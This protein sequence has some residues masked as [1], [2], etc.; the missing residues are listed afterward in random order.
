MATNRKNVLN[1]MFWNAKS[2]KNKIA[3]TADFI[4]NKNID[5]ALFTETW[6]RQNQS[7]SIPN[8]KTYFNNRPDNNAGNRAV[9]GGVAIAINCNIAHSLLPNFN[10]SVIEAIGIEVHGERS[11][12]KIIAVYFPGGKINS[13]KLNLFRRD[14]RLLSGSNSP[15]LICGDLNAR[16]RFWNCVRGNSTGRALYDEMTNHNFLI[17]FP[18]GPT[19]YPSQSGNRTPSTI[20][21]AISSGLLGVGNL[22]TETS[23]NSDHLP[24]T[25]NL[26]LSTVFSNNLA[27]IRCY[28]R[29]NWQKY[30]HEIDHGID[31]VTL[32][33][34]LTNINSIDQTISGFTSII[35]NAQNSS[36][37]TRV[38][39][40]KSEPLPF[41]IKR[42]IN[43]RNC[44]RRQWQRSRSDVLRIE[45]NYLNRQIK[46]QISLMRANAFNKKLSEFKNNSRQLWNVTKFL[47]NGCN[48][49]PALKDDNQRYLTTDNEKANEIG[50]AFCNAHKIT[51]DAKSD[52]QTESHVASSIFNLG[53]LFP[54]P[55]TIKLIKPAEVIRIVST[56]KSRKSPGNDNINNTLIKHLPKR[57]FVLLTYIFNACLR[58]G[59][60]PN[61]WKLAKVI[62][63]PKP[64]K[65]LSSS[66]NYRPI[67]LLSG[68]SKIFERLLL[69]R[70]SSHNATKNLVANEQFGFRQGH[71]TNHQLLRLSRHIRDGFSAGKSTGVITFD[72]EKAF[73]SVWH[74]GLLHKMFVMKYPFYLIKII[75]S[76]LNSRSFYV[77]VGDTKSITFQVAAGVPQGSVLSP[78]LYN[79]FTSDLRVPII[80]CQVALFADDTAFYASAKNPGKIIRILNASAQYL[81]DY[82]SRWKVKL[83]STKTQAV[84]FTKRRAQQ[85]LPDVD[86][87][88]QNASVPW[89]NQIKYLGVTL[90]SKLT[91]GQHVDLTVQKIQKYIAILYPLIGKRSKLGKFNKLILYK[92]FF[93]SI[94]LFA[95]PVWAKCAQCHRDKLQTVQNRCL[96]IILGLPYYFPTD[97]L[98]RIA[99][100]EK[101]DRQIAKIV[102]RFSDKLL[103]SSNPLVRQLSTD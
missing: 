12:T 58:L 50:N 15:F 53:F 82:C 17:H 48:R 66:K 30:K 81:S 39:S 80:G 5:I 1:I 35:E 100:V 90:D 59:Y 22:S 11:S 52:I 7:V 2:L 14:L 45:I 63:I 99:G 60:F 64:G 21:V 27:Y 69:S 55:N 49:L 8:F 34:S 94:L 91:Y 65:D 72:I 9:G 38:F 95:C 84:Y 83:N 79:I 75:Q 96:K 6:L 13:S 98:H 62:P 28:D 102:T 97:A 86:L 92:N 67:S 3:E 25:F 73:D 47:K 57:A 23:L 37:P 33:S 31:L 36:V 18:P 89:L 77:S 93:Q 32:S 103:T 71:S 76:Y 74:N 16:H 101:V 42:I 10:T 46:T 87:T 26:N 70:I 29:A 40:E 4:L 19:H 88:V 68:L 78:T 20:D 24:V 61:S 43:L 56:L 41:S 51:H 85:W 44:L 54:V